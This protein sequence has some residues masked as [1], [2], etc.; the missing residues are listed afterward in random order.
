MP[1]YRRDWSPGATYFF[2]VVTHRRSPLLCTDLARPL[3]HAAFEDCRRECP[4][5]MPAVVLLP[6]HLHAVWTLPPGDDDFAGR[7]AR[8]KG[9]FTR[10]Y[11]SAGGGERSVSA[12]RHRQ[13]RRGV[14][15]PRFWEHL[16]RDEADYE[17]HFDYVHWNPVKHG[18]VPRV[19]DWEWSSFHR[20]VAAGVYPPDWGCG[21]ER[22][23]GAERTTGE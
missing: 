17:R 21:P 2:T 10:Q 6:D 14:W 12:G 3:L 20:W 4:F 11:T 18:H 19:V 9:D 22:F 1:N 7:W 16:I 15:Q 8:I 13:R 23:T 5:D